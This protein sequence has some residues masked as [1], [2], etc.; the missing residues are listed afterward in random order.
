MGTWHSVKTRGP[1][2]VLSLRKMLAVP[3]CEALAPPPVHVVKGP[4]GPSET[5]SL[6]S[7]RLTIWKDLL[8]LSDWRS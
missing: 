2:G 6:C 8:S 3:L 5:R 1:G 4:E 7:L